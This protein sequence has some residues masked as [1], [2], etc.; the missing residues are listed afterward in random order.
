MTGYGLLGVTFATGD[1][2][3][4]RCFTTSSIG[5]PYRSLWHRRPDGRWSMHTNVEPSRAC[6]RYFGPALDSTTVDEID[7]A[8]NGPWEVTVTAA[9]ARLVAAIRL[10]AALRTRILGA[11][12]RAAPAWL[13]ARPR[14]G[15]VAG[16]LLDSGA[17]SIAGRTPTGHTFLVRPRA[18]WRVTAAAAMIDG[19]DMGPV[20]VPAE[21]SSLGEFL[22]PTRGLL[23]AGRVTFG[24][25]HGTALPVSA[26]S[27]KRRGSHA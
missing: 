4:F 3:A 10:E 26:V 23:A 19:R 22:I 6:P 18:L 15:H 13:L 9:R 5:P 12:A 7:I 1:V 14:V 27:R 17:L 16:R 2:I 21:S 8:W 20:A 25:E 11:T 24:A